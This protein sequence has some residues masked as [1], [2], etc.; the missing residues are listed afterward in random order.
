[1]VWFLIKTLGIILLNSNRLWDAISDLK[2]GKIIQILKIS[3]NDH[4][5]DCHKIQP[6]TILR[7]NNNNQQRLKLDSQDAQ[8][9]D[10]N[11]DVYLGRSSNH[12]PNQNKFSNRTPSP[13]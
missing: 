3:D 6:S 13:R 11:S 7:D 1:M 10:R 4:L 5:H 9:K 12:S 8:R 2:L